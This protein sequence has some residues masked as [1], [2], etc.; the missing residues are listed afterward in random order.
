MWA[1][2]PCQR[3]FLMFSVLLFP[4][5]SQSICLISFLLFR[6]S[7]ERV[8]NGTGAGVPYRRWMERLEFGA[9]TV[10][11]GIVCVVHHWS[12]YHLVAMIIKASAVKCLYCFCTA[13]VSINLNKGVLWFH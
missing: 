1:F 13:A 2:I 4:S 6:C 9:F 8:E 12:M 11:V 7:R 10:A 3:D 5:L